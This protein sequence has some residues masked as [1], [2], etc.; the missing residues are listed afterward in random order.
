MPTSPKRKLQPPT[1]H[2]REG[3]TPDYDWDDAMVAESPRQ[4]KA[5]ADETRNTL[6][7][8]LSERA[9]TT[10]HLAEAMGRPKGTIGYHLKV[11][12]D[13]GFIR[14]VRTRK[15]RAMTEK[16]YGR[17]ARSIVMPGPAFGADPFFM[18]REVMREA[19]VEAEA[20]LPMFTIRKARIP[21]DRAVE[22]SGRIMELAEEFLALPREGDAAYGLIA[23]IYPTNLP[24]LPDAKTE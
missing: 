10:S 22:F 18:L 17:T 16:Y 23:G 20:A 4:I 19:V 15:V 9:A 21:A 12:A 7:G 1:T 6:L 5:L 3:H 14:V 8:L 24:V 11:L 2:P 13:A